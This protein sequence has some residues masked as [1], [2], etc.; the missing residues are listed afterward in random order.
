[1]VLNRYRMTAD[2]VKTVSLTLMMCAGAANAEMPRNLNAK[3]DAKYDCEIPRSLSDKR[4]IGF[5]MATHKYDK[6]KLACAADIVLH[7]SN[8]APKDVDLA[9]NALAVSTDYIDHISVLKNADLAALQED[10]WQLRLAHGSDVASE[11]VQRLE[12]IAPERADVIA[13]KGISIVAIHQFDNPAKALMA[14]RESLGLLNRA[15]E[16]DPMVLGGEALVILGRMYYEIPGLFG[17][18]TDKALELYQQAYAQTPKNIQLLRYWAEAWDGEMEEVMAKDIL[19][20]MLPLEPKFSE[21]QRYADELR[22]GGGL[23]E[24]LGD[25]ALSEKLMSKR[26]GLLKT[27]PMLNARKSAAAAGHGGVNPLTGNAQY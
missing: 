4:S 19:I 1:M 20:E 18:D 11:L 5:E 12:K 26:A 25:I 27:Y 2:I 9:V 17:G 21:L 6:N 14:I 23:S 24:R 16:K 15:V 13:L 3:E 22:L 7:A 8:Q 10:E